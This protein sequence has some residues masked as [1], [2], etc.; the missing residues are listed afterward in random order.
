MDKAFLASITV[1]FLKRSFNYLMLYLAASTYI[2]EVDFACSI[3][4]TFARDGLAWLIKGALAS[5]EVLDIGA[6][7]TVELI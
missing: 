4:S 2:F 3:D 6:D 1:L 5:D 7:Y